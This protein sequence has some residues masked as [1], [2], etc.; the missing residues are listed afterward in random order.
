MLQY[1]H[2]KTTIAICNI[3]TFT[4]PRQILLILS[5][6][7]IR[8]KPVQWRMT[9]LKFKECEVINKMRLLHWQDRKN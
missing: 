1:S 6:V 4:T 2:I 9:L 5:Y 3:Y 8:D 7:K